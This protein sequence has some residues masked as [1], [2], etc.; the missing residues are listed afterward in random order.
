MLDTWGR[1]DILVNNAAIDDPVGLDDVTL[2]QWRR[3]MR[4]NL[5]GPFHLATL[6]IPSMRD[7]AY[8]R[9]IN[10]SSGSVVNPMVGF[11][12]YRA[13]KMGL[14]GMTR[15]LATE[16]GRDGITANVVSPGVTETAMALTNLTPEFRA[17]AL[18]KQGVKRIGQPSDLA[19]MI[20]YVASPEAEFVTG[21][22]LM[23]NGGA[24]FTA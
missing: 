8:G 23:V 9:I 18:E 13:S 1:V 6:V 10:I 14:I 2:E 4:V 7:H 12:A 5:E 21:Q 19:G 3:I 20:A 24:A 15:A 22:N 11:V 17:K 16:L